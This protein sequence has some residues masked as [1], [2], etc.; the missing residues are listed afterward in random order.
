MKKFLLLIF[1][2]LF[3]CTLPVE[4]GLIPTPGPVATPTA[5]AAFTLTAAVPSPDIPLGSAKNP[6]ILALT[7]STHPTQD[8]INAG[9]VLTSA[10]ENST[11]YSF[12]SVIPPNET[13]LVRAFGNGSA[14]IGVLT[15]FGYLLASSQDYV[16]AAFARQQNGNTFY[17]AQ[18]IV[19]SDA[20]FTSYYD[21][22]KAQNTADVTAALAQF[23]GKKPCWAD[24]FSPSGYVVPLGFLGEAG[25]KTLEPAFVAGQPTVVRAVYAGGICDFGATYI[26]ARAYPGLE[27]SFPDVNQKVMIVWQTPSIIPYEV[28]VYA[29]GMT[30]DM[31]RVL[32]R[33]FVD[34]MSTPD[35]SSAMQTLYGFNAMD[36]I[37]DGQYDEFRKAVKA[38]GLDLNMLVR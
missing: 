38:S 7:P 23:D 35:G 1:V 24:E 22:V 36:V 12:V 28:L 8:V 11:G 17:G 15:P 16:T 14:H 3:A 2:G 10:L 34:L 18:F 4:G 25:V 9:K 6:L 30:V 33:A 32:T 5:A 20:G 31:S 26:D 37:R 29:H 21:P 27:D 19:R 13:E